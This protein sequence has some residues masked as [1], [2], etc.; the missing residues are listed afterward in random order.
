VQNIE[1]EER[2]GGYSNATIIIPQDDGSGVSDS[3][4]ESESKDCQISENEILKIS[5]HWVKLVIILSSYEEIGA[6]L[7]LCMSKWGKKI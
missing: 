4:S 6:Q 7:Y 1:I 5:Y 2:E 3:G